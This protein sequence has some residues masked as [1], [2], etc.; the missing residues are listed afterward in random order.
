MQDSIKSICC[1]GEGYEAPRMTGESCWL[2]TMLLRGCEEGIDPKTKDLY[3]MKKP[4]YYVIDAGNFLD[5][6]L[7][8]MINNWPG[9]TR[10]DDILPP[11]FRTLKK[12]GGTVD[13]DVPALLPMLSDYYELRGWIEEGR[14]KPKTIRRLELEAFGARGT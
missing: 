7:K 1:D 14:P 11:R 9:F 10:K 2:E 5:E 6:T 3:P 13:L 12:R 8:R 4:P